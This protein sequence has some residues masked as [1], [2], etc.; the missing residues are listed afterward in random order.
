MWRVYFSILCRSLVESLS[1]HPANF[2]VTSMAMFYA[3]QSQSKWNGW[4]Q[5]VQKKKKKK[6]VNV[7]LFALKLFPTHH[8]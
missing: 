7:S 2:T 3:P 8:S 6:K 5:Q 4:R 1:I